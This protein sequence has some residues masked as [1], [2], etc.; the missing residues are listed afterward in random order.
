[1]IMSHIFLLPLFQRF[2][3]DMSCI[4]PAIPLMIMSHMHVT[5]SVAIISALLLI[6]LYVICSTNNNITAIARLPQFPLFLP[7]L[8]FPLFPPF[9]PF[10]PA[11]TVVIDEIDMVSYQM[12]C[13]VHRRLTEIKGTDDVVTLFGG[14][15]VIAVRDFLQ[16]PPVCYIFA[17]AFVML[18]NN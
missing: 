5:V 2:T 6:M 10:L 9:P 8:P 13:F 16:L 4:F 15:N 14:L 3:Y 11:H 12:L 1:M 17:T 7:F 18:I